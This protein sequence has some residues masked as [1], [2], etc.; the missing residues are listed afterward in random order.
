LNEA[1]GAVGQTQIDGKTFLAVLRA[2]KSE[3]CACVNVVKP[4][5]GRF[6]VCGMTHK[7][8]R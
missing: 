5:L 6:L 2:R 7:Y 1:A 3:M 4:T 8:T